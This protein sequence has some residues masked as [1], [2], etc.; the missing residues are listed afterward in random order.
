MLRVPDTDL[1]FFSKLLDLDV[2]A[3][4]GGLERTKAEFHACS[5]RPITG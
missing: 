3:M 4:T 5:M 1:M 2:L